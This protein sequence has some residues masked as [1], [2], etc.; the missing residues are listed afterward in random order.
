[1]NEI[2]IHVAIGFLFGTGIWIIRQ[3]IYIGKALWAIDEILEK[4]TKFIQAFYLIAKSAYQNE[5]LD[6]AEVERILKESDK[7]D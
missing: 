7:R 1:M 5:H 2:L 6:V 3:L 4:H